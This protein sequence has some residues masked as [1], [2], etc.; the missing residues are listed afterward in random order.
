M[1]TQPA[2]H[3]R[4]S[5]PPEIEDLIDAVLEGKATAEQV[6]RLRPLLRD[7]P[8]ALE[9]YVDQARMHA[10]LLWRH[11]QAG[12]A[13]VPEEPVAAPTIMQ[14][15]PPPRRWRIGWRRLAVAAV[16]LLSVGLAMLLWP[17]RVSDGPPVPEM[18]G[19]VAAMRDV[20]WGEGQTALATGANV[21]L[22]PLS[23]RSGTLRLTLRSDVIVT[24]T[25]SAKVQFLS[26][27]RMR[28]DEGQITARVGPTGKGFT[29]ESAAAQVVDQGT[30]FGMR[31]DRSGRADVL[32]FEGQVDLLRSAAPR[33]TAGSTTRPAAALRMSK[34]Q[35]LHVALDGQVQRI[36]AVEGKPGTPD[37][38]VGGAPAGGNAVIARVEDNLRDL[39]GGA[40]NFY[41]IVHRGLEE[42]APAYVDRC[43]EWNGVDASGIPAEL[44]GADLVM[45]FNS[46][47][48][49]PDLKITVT[50]ARP[51]A[52]Y[53][54]LQASAT[55]PEWLVRDFV[56]TPLAIG[57]DEGPP[58]MPHL[59]LGQGPGQSIDRPFT[60]WRREVPQAGAVTL[61]DNAPA[62]SMYG[63]AATPLP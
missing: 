28:A 16:M 41:R 31:V 60:V 59:Q 40:G 9:A 44:K 61:G 32:V 45:T 23:I 55:P 33:G 43:Y 17:G 51:A 26:P 21:G 13:V 29:V 56:Q 37:W 24:L 58:D 14:I 57:L 18:L 46:D 8:A 27:M 62:K 48:K 12:P 39:E 1:S 47:K 54:F 25:G 10:L 38:V 34:G 11:G 4:E 20:V 52:L 15:E 22:Q 36:V 5:H 19:T 2:G 7:D 53:V 35:G 6:Q 30:E 3:Y 63:I 49:T 50:L 42:D